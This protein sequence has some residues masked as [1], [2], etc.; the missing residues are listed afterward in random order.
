MCFRPFC[1]RQELFMLWRAITV[2][3]VAS[4]FLSFYLQMQLLGVGACAHPQPIIYSP[5][6]IFISLLYPL[7]RKFQL[8]TCAHPHPII[9][10]LLNPCYI[11]FHLQMQLLGT[12]K[13]VPI[14]SQSSTPLVPANNPYWRTTAC[15]AHRHHHHHHHSFANFIKKN[16]C[17]MFAIIVPLL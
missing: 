6:K 9:C 12:T 1:L 15:R 7:C 4:H 11:C 3:Q 17:I 16:H 13:R 2:K 8:G 5:I 14:H 10:S